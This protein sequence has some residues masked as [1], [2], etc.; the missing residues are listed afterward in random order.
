MNGPRIRVAHASGDPPRAPRAWIARCL[1][2]VVAWTC[3]APAAAQAPA[4]G[5][6][7]RVAWLVS[8]S[9]ADDASF[10]D[11]TRAAL[12]DLG[13]VEGANLQLEARYANGDSSRLPALAAELVARKPDVIIA[14]ATPGTLAAARATAT[15]PIVMIG[16]ADPVG[17]GFVDDLA[18][19]GRNVTGIANLGV[20]TAGKPLE[21]L[22]EAL[23]KATRIAVLTSDNPG[24]LAVAQAAREAFRAQRLD[25]RT[26]AVAGVQDLDRAVAAIKEAR[27]DGVVVVADGLLIA[28]RERLA[29]L[30]LEARL[31]SAAT[32][33]A[34]ADAGVLMSVGPNPR[35]LHRSVARYVDR[36]L[37]GTPP[38]ALAVELP[39][40]F[41][42]AVNLRTA[43][44]L[45]LTLPQ[46]LLLRADRVIE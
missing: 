11:A 15:I 32:Y 13:Y 7:Y 33:A 8:G 14:G 43:R 17:A 28:H 6:T 37:K 30:L 46:S 35:N 38:S 1:I 29:R 12:R 20:D 2:A 5:R 36:I 4:A 16:V 21:M 31:P 22:R 26:T 9:P 45:N 27:A 3:V 24:A 44:A 10:Q 41:T 19:P 25:V 23:P 39:T 34:L 40:E 18:R 42:V